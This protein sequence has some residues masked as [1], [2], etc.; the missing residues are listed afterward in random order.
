MYYTPKLTYTM[1]SVLTAKF[2]SVS[3]FLNY[4]ERSHSYD[5]A[6]YMKALEQKETEISKK[7]RKIK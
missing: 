7:I 3:A 1:K 2:M 5:L 4:V 6:A